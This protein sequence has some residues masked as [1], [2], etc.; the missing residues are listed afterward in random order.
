MLWRC[1][2]DPVQLEAVILNLAANARDAMNGSG[3]LTIA[4]DNVVMGARDDV[5]LA[6]GEYI[7]VSA[8]DTGCGMTRKV[9]KR[10]RP[11]I[12]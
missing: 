9:M 4:A 11:M 8:S 10:E 5:E 6:A 7:V 3:R 2:I 12:I 1:R